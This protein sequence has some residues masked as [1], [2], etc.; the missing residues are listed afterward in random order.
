MGK[1]NPL[2]LLPMDQ[3][4]IKTPKP[5]CRLVVKIDQYRYL[6][7]GVYLSEA[8]DPPLPLLHT[9]SENMYPCTIHTGKVGGGGR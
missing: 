7:A 5:K 1:K 4:S 3:I 6:A 9:L 8:P 2:F